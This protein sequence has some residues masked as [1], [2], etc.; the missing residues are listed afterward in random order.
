LENTG[1]GNGPF[2]VPQAIGPNDTPTFAGLELGLG[3]SGNPS[4]KFGPNE[5][6]F[7]LSPGGNDSIVATIQ[8]TDAWTFGNAAFS[9]VGVTGGARINR[10]AGSTTSPT[11]TFGGDL[12]S[13]LSRSAANQL[14]L[15]T[16]ALERMRIDSGG[17]VGVGVAPV[18]S[19]A[20]LLHIGGDVL[21]IGT[22]RTPASAGAAGNAGEIA[23]DSGFLYVCTATNTWK[24]VAIATW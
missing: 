12:I 2:P 6:G 13:G 1:I 15:I 3:S 7:W 18:L 23:W 22:S 16:N 9:S 4:L 24:R 8:G 17:L 19:G 5:S 10:A 21:R 14:S 20:G 11:F